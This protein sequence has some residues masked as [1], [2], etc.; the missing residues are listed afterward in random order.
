MAGGTLFPHGDVELVVELGPTDQAALATVATV[1][2][3]G[4]DEASR[5]VLPPGG[6]RRSL[7]YLP[8]GI[9]ELQLDLAGGSREPGTVR[10]QL[11]RLGTVQSAVVRALPAL[12]R[13]VREPERFGAVARRAWK[14]LRED[15]PR[16]ILHALRTGE[17]V[18]RGRRYEDWVLLYDSLGEEERARIR[19]AVDALP[20]RPT[21]SVVMPVW[22]TPERLLR[23]AIGSVQRQLYPH[24]E[25]CIADDHSD[26]PEVRR[27]L[28]ELA[29]VEPRI[30]VQYR[31][32][33]GHISAASNT[34]LELA[35][36]EFVTFLDHDD[37]LPEHA[38]FAV[39]ERICAHPDAD[40]LY[41]DEDKIDDAGRRHTPAFKPDWSPELLRSQ[42]YVC[43]LAV[44]RTDLVRRVGGLRAGFEGSQDHD[45][46]LRCSAR[47]DA[48]RI[49]HLP[50]ILYHWRMRPG[51]TAA[52]VEE[53]P[54]AWIAGQRAVQDA[55][56]AAGV[57]ARVELGPGTGTYHVRYALPVPAPLTS[58]IIPTR[59]RL[60][61]LEQ[62]ITSVRERTR[63]APYELLLVD[64]D[65]REAGTLRYLN[66]LERTCAAR[67]LRH[68][69]AFNFSAICNAAVQA[70]RGELVC[71]LNNDVMVISPEW[72]VE[73]AGLALQGGVGA[74]GAKLYYPNDT[75]QHAG[76]VGGLFGTV[77][78]HF[79]L[80]PRGSGGYLERLRIVREVLA[81]TAACLVIRRKLY[82]ELGGLN[83]TELQVA[84]ND[85]DLCLRLWARG[86]RNLWTPHAELY[87]H[88]SMSR[89]SDEDPANRER[90]AGEMAHLRSTWGQVLEQ[91]PYYNPNLSVRADI[92]EPAWPPRV[93]HTWSRP[94]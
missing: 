4:A 16:G 51:S 62:C 39:A 94:G 14:L 65:S 35:R 15:G 71:L 76:V 49:H 8:R 32:T 63:S 36:G 93:V 26:Q 42:N 45:L 5:I 24:W 56:D 54:Y 20:F 22:N 87:H 41:S 25:L 18:H 10:A 57:R 92:P 53:K 89:G 68:P 85:V 84:Y 46:A 60:R 7:I 69:G 37:E 2:A 64:N 27:T 31:T 80:S 75:V 91:D 47:T 30:R 50:A 9:L 3:S 1:T 61:L 17:R 43:H 59:D 38:L 11:R 34:A 55:V 19:A 12:R 33:T 6:S 44:Y 77:G 79:R 52:G 72:L 74:V 28:E 82:L 21:F 48:A 86:Y 90:F 23:R 70:T 29:S 78:H 58:I 88:E 40:I 13:L 66:R 81:V 83:E 67:V 73:M